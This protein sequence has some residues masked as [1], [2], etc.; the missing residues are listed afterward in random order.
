M[1]QEVQF[2]SFDMLT[3]EHV[4]DATVHVRRYTAYRRVTTSINVIKVF[5]SL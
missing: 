5:S 4:L 1:R 3:L 2:K